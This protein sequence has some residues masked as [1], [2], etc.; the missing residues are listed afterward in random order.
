MLP[1]RKGYRN[2]PSTARERPHQPPHCKQA[3]ATE[4]PRGRQVE[5]PRIERWRPAPAPT[6]THP[7]RQRGMRPRG[8]AKPPRITTHHDHNNQAA[9]GEP[10]PPPLDRHQRERISRKGVLSPS[11]HRIEAARMVPRPPRPPIGGVQI[12]EVFHACLFHVCLGPF[13]GPEQIPVRICMAKRAQG[14][15]IHRVRAVSA[16]APRYGVV[17]LQVLGRIAQG[18]PVVVPRI[19]GFPGLTVNAGADHGYSLL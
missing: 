14:N 10:G 1:G 8:G 17:D 4:I 15:E 5:P 12:C 11:L 6:T 3:G 7:G 19:D 18:A 13:I 2:S 9:R 16:T